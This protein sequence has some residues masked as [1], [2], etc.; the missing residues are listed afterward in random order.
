MLSVCVSVAFSRCC[1]AHYS[2]N[3]RLDAHARFAHIAHNYEWW[4]I[5]INPSNITRA[6]LYTAS[7]HYNDDGA[8]KF[9]IAVKRYGD[10]LWIYA[11]M[12]STVADDDDVDRSGM[13]NVHALYYVLC[14]SHAAAAAA[15]AGC[16]VLGLLQYLLAQL[17]RVLPHSSLNGCIYIQWIG[18]VGARTNAVIVKRH[19]RL[20]LQLLALMEILQH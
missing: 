5:L 15:A 17:V 4:R 7:Y 18:S 10:V 1:S 8:K 11:I 12:R 19:M 2:A 6:H 16:C 14:T 20:R 9:A 3:V 13:Y